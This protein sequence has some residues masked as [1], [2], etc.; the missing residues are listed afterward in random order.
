MEKKKDK[1]LSLV[2]TISNLHLEHYECLWRA[3]SQMGNQPCYI[4]ILFLHQ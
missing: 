3:T 2:I 1:T 4:T